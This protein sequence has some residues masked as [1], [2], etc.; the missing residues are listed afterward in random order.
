VFAEKAKNDNF[1][2]FI[3]VS[4]YFTITDVFSAHDYA[5]GRADAGVF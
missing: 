3:L 5:A 1:G 2:P 4:I